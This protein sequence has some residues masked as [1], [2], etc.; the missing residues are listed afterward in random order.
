MVLLVLEVLVVLE[1]GIE[2]FHALP[3]QKSN[4]GNHT[5]YTSG[6]ESPSAE[7]NHDNLISRGVI[8][9]NKTVDFTDVL[10]SY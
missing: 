9:R 4:V 7:S 1:D 8:G 6:R 2:V 10:I 5:S 3:S